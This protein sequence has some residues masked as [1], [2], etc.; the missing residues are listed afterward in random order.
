MFAY[1][2]FVLLIALLLNF[3]VSFAE[4]RGRSEGGT[5]TAEFHYG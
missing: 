2:V 4:A 3:A 5:S 1:I